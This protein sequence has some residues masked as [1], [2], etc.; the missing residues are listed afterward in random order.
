MATTSEVV[1]ESY[2][3]LNELSTSNLYSTE[4]VLQCVND[5]QVEVC[6]T[7]KYNF[8]KTKALYLGAANTQLQAI[9]TTASTTLSVTDTT[10]FTATNGAVLVDQDVINYATKTA[11]TLLTCTNIGIGHD[12]GANVIPLFTLPSDYSK[13]PVLDVY[14]GT[15]SRP[16]SFTYVDEE[17]FFYSQITNRFTLVTSE[18]GVRYIMVYML[19]NTDR[20]VFKYLKKPT[21]LVDDTD[22][23]TI[24]DPY[25][26]KVVPIFTAARCQM[27]RGDNLD[28][29][30][31]NKYNMARQELFKMNKHFGEQEEGVRKVI[32]SAYKSR[33]TDYL[34]GSSII[35]R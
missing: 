12:S 33:R 27:L 7:Q 11:T 5:V 32:Q 34:Y 16:L 23:L 35:R 29:E 15:N 24:P 25:A 10:N 14:K 3:I 13:R 20:L 31:L 18:S 1:N 8:L 17:E 19:S 28:G 30:A 9:I 26:L 21:T 4:Y 6:D 22:V 2:A